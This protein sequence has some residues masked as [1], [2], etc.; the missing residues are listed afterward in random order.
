MDY[1]S[2]SRSGGEPHGSG[3]FWDGPR[4][5]S[6]VRGYLVPG[7]KDIGANKMPVCSAENTRDDASEGAGSVAIVPSVYLG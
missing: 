5:W 7:M 6:C 4:G 3:G 2:P 1:L